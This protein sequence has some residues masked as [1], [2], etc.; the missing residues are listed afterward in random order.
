[1]KQNV[2]DAFLVNLDIKHL[3]M[4]PFH[5][6]YICYTPTICIQLSKIYSKM[7]R[8]MTML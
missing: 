4:A 2:N 7:T 6:Q 5:Q 1:M 8:H 3:V